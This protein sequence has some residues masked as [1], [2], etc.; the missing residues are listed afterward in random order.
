MA[1][2]QTE[3]G[4]LAQMEERLK[5]TGRTLSKEEFH[6]EL[7]YWRSHKIIQKMLD[8]GLITPDEFRKI[9]ALNRKSF[10]PGLAQLMA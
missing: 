1:Q 6:G 2:L 5:K 8:R 9:D 4:F 7:N 3:P 10:S